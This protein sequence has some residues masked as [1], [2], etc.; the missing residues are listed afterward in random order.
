MIL[1]V[2]VE[3]MFKIDTQVGS[4]INHQTSKSSPTCFPILSMLQL[5]LD[6]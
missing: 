4:N 2:L 1:V 5:R 3:E 6:W